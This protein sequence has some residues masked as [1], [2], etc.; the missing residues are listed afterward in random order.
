V[1]A[2]VNVAIIGAGPYGLSVSAY[3]TSVGIQHRIVGN[4][5]ELWRTQMPRGMLLKSEGFASSLADP[6]GEFSLK[7]Y[8]K[9]HN[10]RYADLGTPVSLDTFCAYGA[11]FQ[12][13]L[14]PHLEDKKLKHLS[15]SPNG[16]ILELENG[17]KF[18][19]Q[20]V[21]L[22]VG[23]SHFRYIPP[24]LAGLPSDRVSH[25]S[26]HSEPER[27]KG[28]DVVVVGA[29]SSAID[30]SAAL[31]ENGAK[32]QMISRRPSV[33]IHD[34][35][36][37]PRSF[38]EKALNPMSGIGLGWPL[39]AFCYAP[40]V[41][42]HMPSSFRV[43]AVKRILGPAAGWFMKDRFSSVPTLVGQTVKS[44][45]TS[46]T[47]VTLQLVGRDGI[48]RSVVTEHVIA[49]TGYRTDLGRLAFLNQDI[50]SRLATIETSPELSS[51][52]ESSVR[53][54]YF[55]GAAAA[56]SFGPV[57]RFAV[58]AKFAARRVSK[59]LARQ[60]IAVRADQPRLGVSQ[61]LQRGETAS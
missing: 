35:M 54:L 58:G 49:A 30:L 21:V 51:N 60:L 17:E 61:S 18:E 20:K 56:Y 26:E 39:M 41:I 32:V 53:G 52:F 27:L 1:S 43:R 37:L 24:E 16:F 14:V 6:T 25:S 59:H 47:G 13:R 2:T 57:M 3:L 50:R 46:D 7:R 34:K 28:R 44:A 4:P 23:V 29:G 5:M 31:A 33:L 12:N 45:A 55:V 11:A 42:H 36:K 38:K 10:I 9:D 15:L 22:A 48:E 19:A 40:H 8:C